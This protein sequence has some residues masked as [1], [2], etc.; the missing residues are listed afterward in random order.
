MS[1]NYSLSRLIFDL[2]EVK[3]KE[4]GSPRRKQNAELKRLLKELKHSPNSQDLVK[5]TREQER[6]FNEMRKRKCCFFFTL[7]VC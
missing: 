1:N 3:G 2:V 6:D 5:R 7:V 4:E